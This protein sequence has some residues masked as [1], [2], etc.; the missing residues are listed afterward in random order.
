MNCWKQKLETELARYPRLAIAFSGGCD[1]ALLA[2]AARRTLGSANVLLLL[3]DSELLPREEFTRA[4]KIA[5]ESGLR[6]EIVH[7][8]PLSDPDVRA[9]GPRRCYHCKKRLFSALAERA[10]ELGFPLLAD[11]ANRDDRNDYRPGA[12]AAD[13][14]GIVHPL[15]ELP[16]SAIRELAR[17]LGVPVWNLPAA[18][19][20][21]S[22]IP[23]GTPLEQT[24]LA[25][26]EAG[27][28]AIAELGYTGCRVRRIGPESARL[29]L[30]PGEK[31][32]AKREFEAI[33]SR[34]GSCG[35]STVELADYRIG[36]MNR[37][38]EKG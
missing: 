5:E 37:P 14:L 17:E 32:R 2:A 13:E 33:R 38:V 18:A 22:R 19:C 24:A 30:R 21:A 9:N 8:D 16:K 34:L 15:A 27:E 31:E 12:Q 20:L 6:L 35:F 1:S 23:T 7:P 11:G 29:E 10:R 28:R 4:E 3:A 25:A 36:S 26:V